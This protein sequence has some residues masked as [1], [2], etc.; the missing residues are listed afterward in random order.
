MNSGRTS[1]APA[2]SGTLTK[3]DEDILT[4][5][6]TYRI[7][8]PEILGPLFFSEADRSAM[9]KVLS[10]LTRAG[11]LER[12]DL[13]PPKKYWT[14]SPAAA[15]ARGLTSEFSNIGPQALAQAYA[16]LYYC[17]S[18][19][20]SVS[21]RHITRLELLS[22]R[23]QFAIKGLP[24]QDYFLETEGE[25]TRLGLLI[26]D[27]GANYFRVLRKCRTAT[28]KR[29]AHDAF[30]ALIDQNRF[31]VGI[32]TYHEKKR[33]RMQ[34]ALNDNEIE[35]SIRYTIEVVPELGHLIQRKGPR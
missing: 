4:H 1:T 6:A 16:T 12:R 19:P 2:F 26:V 29:Y 31:I 27:H 30:R 34:T 17:C 11:Y 18:P 5:I 7:T 28:Q 25:T 32:A 20:S 23:P 8:V 9:T 21:R 35:V 13:Y 10:R 3:R 24:S 33:E 22:D 14:L 15:T